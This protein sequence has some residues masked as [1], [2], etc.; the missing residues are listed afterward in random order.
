M[1]LPFIAIEVADNQKGI[2]KYLKKKRIPVLKIRDVR[3]L[4]EKLY[5]FNR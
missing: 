1:N 3:K 4:G 5:R 2:A